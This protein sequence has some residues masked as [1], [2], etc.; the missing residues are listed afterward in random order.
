MGSVLYIAQPTGMEEWVSV[1]RQTGPQRVHKTLNIYGMRTNFFR[2]QIL[3]KKV[4]NKL[5]LSILQA[6]VTIVFV[7][8]PKLYYLNPRASL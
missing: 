2:K 8:V 7:I 5:F 1:R 4:V 3:I 6:I